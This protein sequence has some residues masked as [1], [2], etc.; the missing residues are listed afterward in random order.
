MAVLCDIFCD[1][2][3]CGYIKTD[4]MVNTSDKDHGICDKCKIGKMKRMVANKMTFEL[5]YDN[6]TDSCDW[7]G[8]TTR[9]WDGVK[10]AQAKGE[11]VEVPE[12]FRGK[13]Y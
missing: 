10:Q 3:K 6:K 11:K 9:L 7:D 4:V 1:N 13:W 12:K 8:N 5:V 2:P